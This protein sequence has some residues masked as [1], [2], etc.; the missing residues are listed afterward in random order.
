M[1]EEARGLELDQRRATGR[2]VLHQPEQLLRA[3]TVNGMRAL[4]WEA[5]ELK[6]GMLADF[7][8]LAQPNGLWRELGPAYL[9][10]GYSG[11]DVTNVVVGGETVV[12]R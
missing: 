5:G 9:V 10:Y 2:R 8:T 11:R 7:I 6:E 4:G 1:L 12:Q 3:A